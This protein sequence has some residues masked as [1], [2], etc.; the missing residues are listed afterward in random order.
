MSITKDGAA[1]EFYSA[2]RSKQLLETV[3][4]TT[5][6]KYLEMRMKHTT[7]TTAKKQHY[8]SVLKWHFG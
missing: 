7:T 1:T 2:L 8:K 4:N 6:V 5:A 3:A